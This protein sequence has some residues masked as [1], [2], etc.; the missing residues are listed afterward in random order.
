M[1]TV[2]RRFNR[3][4]RS[5]L[6]VRADGYC[7]MCG[8]PLEKGWHADHVV[9]FAHGGATNI[10]NGQA[11]CGKCNLRK[12]VNVNKRYVWQDEARLAMDATFSESD[13]CLIHATPGSGKTR[14]GLK[15]FN[16][17][18]SSNDVRMLL[19]VVPSS[20]LRRQWAVAAKALGLDLNATWV[21]GDGRLPRDYAGLVVTYQA[22]VK[23]PEAF[24]QFADGMVILDEVYHCGQHLEW[25]AQMQ[26]AV[27]R[28]PY[29]LLL[30]G[31]PFRSDGQPIPF[32]E[33]DQDGRCI[34]AYSFTYGKA[35]SYETVRKVYF[36]ARGGTAIWLENGVK[37]EADLSDDI[38][39]YDTRNRL[40]TFLNPSLDSV[41]QMLTAANDEL[42]QI[43][44]SGKATRDALG[45]VVCKD[46]SHA[47]DVHA[48]LC[49]LGLRAKIATSDEDDACEVIDGF[50]KDA[51]DR[52][53]VAVDMVSE[54]VDI[55]RAM[56]L[57]IL[58]NKKTELYFNQMV[59]RVV[60]RRGKDDALAI[61]LYPDDPDFRRFAMDI[62]K[63]V[64]H[65]VTLEL[66][67][68]SVGDGNGREEHDG[69]NSII[70]MFADSRDAGVVINGE[71]IGTAELKRAE[72]LRDQFPDLNSVELA[73][74][75]KIIRAATNG[76]NTGVD[77][78][79][80]RSAAVMKDDENGILR[81]ALQRAV[82]HISA[83]TAIPHNQVNVEIKRL[84]FGRFIKAPHATTD[85]L[86]Q[87]LVKAKEWEAQIHATR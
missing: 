69:V 64:D 46:Q 63:D 15:Y 71:W 78:T 12:G 32:V 19:V 33:Y 43:R 31:T 65:Q 14:L 53:L 20:R 61:V 73:T 17:L 28:A 56:V 34:P 58:T 85:E 50:G 49:D 4:E 1:T 36:R 60:R 21:A 59:G 23:N 41:R 24:R 87:M 42:E 35:L 72:D 38:S 18:Y 81:N 39:E 86:R 3:S 48:L 16:K 74:V 44:D 77:A 10:T 5:A 25:G 37:V 13:S 51:N 26:A 27:G 22:I 62:E 79:Q 7:E 76:G 54:G 84:A 82:S 29:K 55:P 52:W 45:L 75:V 80:D 6:F 70:P 11:L 40:N 2:K 47:R 9:P 67:E 83:K 57:V 66:E 8:V 30:T 68:E